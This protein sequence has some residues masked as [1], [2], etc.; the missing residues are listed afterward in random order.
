M[1]YLEL[2]SSAYTTKG[3]WYRLQCS[4]YTLELIDMSTSLKGFRI[5]YKEGDI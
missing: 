4:G 1:N 5:A 3:L 2:Y